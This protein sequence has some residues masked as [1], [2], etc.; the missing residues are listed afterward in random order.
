MHTAL[1]LFFCEED[2][3]RLAIKLLT[4]KEG[5]RQQLAGT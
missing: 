2:V 3:R 4:H 1:G 5:L